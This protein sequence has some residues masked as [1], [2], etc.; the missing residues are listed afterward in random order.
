MVP[1][2]VVI[3]NTLPFPKQRVILSI[4][5]S[6]IPKKNEKGKCLLVVSTQVE[7]TDGRSNT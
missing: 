1:E 5:Q 2:L 3:A 7:S 6:N 4:Q